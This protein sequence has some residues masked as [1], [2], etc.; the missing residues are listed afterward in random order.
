MNNILIIGDTQIPFTIKG[1]LEF[2]LDISKRC[3]CNKFI[4]IGDLVDNHAI[5]YH[6]HDPNGLS[7]KDEIDL[8]KNKLKDW[9]KAFPEVYLCRGNHDRMVDRKGR[10][11]G[12]PDCVFKPFRDIWE[13]PKGWKDDFKWEFD[14]VIFEHGTG[15][16]GDNAHVKAAYNNRQS[17]VIGHVHST[18]A[19]TYL[20]NERDCIF[21]MNV[22]C[23][24][25]R[26]TYAFEYGRDFKKKPIISCGVVTDKGRFAQV[27]PMPL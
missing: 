15:Y 19:I 25:D 5:S 3:K 26:H 23:G 11:V 10:T 16:S 27:F 7:P 4:H 6:E 2:C 24:L 14:N 13:L 12:L 20:A 22:G 17:T 21:G 1:Y 8:A 9:F 18:A